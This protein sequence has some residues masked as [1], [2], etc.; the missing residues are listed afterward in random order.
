VFAVVA[1]AVG[2]YYLWELRA[3]GYR[4]DWKNNQGG[5][6]NY[7]GRA[8]ARGRL[9]LPIQPSPKLLALPNPWDPAVDDSY[10]MH[11]MALYN[12]RYYLYH[13]AGPAVLLFAPY[14][15][16]TGHDLS[17]RFAL[18]LLCFG[19]FAF[20]AAVLMQWFDLAGARIGLPT[21]SMM[22]LAVGLCQCVPYLLCRVWVYE[23]AIGAGY[24]CVSGAL[25]FLT[26]GIQSKRSSYWLGASGLMFGLAIAC[27][28]HLGLAWLSALAALVVVLARSKPALRPAG[29]IAFVGAFAVVAGAVAAYNYQRFGNPF[30][31]G[32]RYLLSGPNQ[33]RIRLARENILPGLYFWLACAPDFSGV[34]PWMRLALRYPFN[35]PAYS[36]PAGYFIEATVGAFY[37]APF[38][39]GAL[40]VPFLR[41]VVRIL[42]CAV[43]TFSAGVLL[44]LAATGFTTQRYEVDFLP[45]VVLAA[46]AA[47]GIYIGSR[48]RATR[49]I[50]HVILV[51]AIAW[52]VVANL[53]LAM[54]G[55]FDEILKNRPLTYLRIARWFSP[56]E[57]FRPMMNPAVRV[58]FTADFTAQ[59]DHV[60]E[61]L[62]TMGHQ[63][64]RYLLYAEHSA[65]KLQLVSW[66]ENSSVAGV[67]ADRDDQ[68]AEI[69]VT[70]APGTGSLAVTVN[71]REALVHQIGTLVTAPADVVIGE[72]RIE[73]GV[74]RDR[75]AGR[76]YNVVK[77]VR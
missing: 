58:A 14:Y 4:F 48:Q 7:L 38:M 39:A 70:F 73:S 3:A 34:F 72:N 76:I 74:T 29:V 53:A 69:Q 8:F 31:F 6:Y 30:E 68:P 15:R 25:F 40:L 49:A 33:N 43:L 27:R 11:D 41:G 45:H 60:R 22:L 16:I 36:F 51:L 24:F 55:P 42:L 37:L 47:L 71:G 59:E 26:R 1:A 10:K 13:G 75:F 32:I 56:I 52:G 66:S 46:L 65:G 61:P 20:S 5:Y 18:F 23:V 62:L 19:G 17:E 50:L 21:L 2:M 35:S 57:E 54:S 77:S 28:P 64:Y 9:A 63:A 12:G 44:F 67:M